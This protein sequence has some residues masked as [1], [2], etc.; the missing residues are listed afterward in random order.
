VCCDLLLIA[1]AVQGV[2]A[3]DPS[4]HLDLD[5]KPIAAR[6]ARRFVTEHLAD[7][8]DEGALTLL[9]SELVTNGVLH[10]RTHLRLGLITGEHRVL[11]TCGDDDP[12]GALAVPPLDH[13]RPSGRGLMLVDALSSQWGVYR[14]ANGKTV[15][16]TLPRGD[17]IAIG[18]GDGPR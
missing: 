9:T 3:A 1:Q 10:A 13:A 4:F 6:E 11:V 15:W 2:S 5:A 14:S 12:N 8:V 16:F 18:G 17:G 7:L